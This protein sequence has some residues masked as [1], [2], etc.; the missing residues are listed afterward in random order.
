[1]RPATKFRTDPAL[2]SSCKHT[3]PSGPGVRRTTL[4]QGISDWD[5][6]KGCD[7]RCGSFRG[8]TRKDDLLLVSDSC[9]G[10]GALGSETEIAMDARTVDRE[11]ADGGGNVANHERA[12]R[13]LHARIAGTH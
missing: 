9:C 8:H 12:V 7:D 10:Y 3:N 2:G 11:I 13:R 5:A 1:M 4:L 6:A